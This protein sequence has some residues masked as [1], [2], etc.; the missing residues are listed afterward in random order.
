MLR[1]LIV[2]RLKQQPVLIKIV[3]A[4]EENDQ[5]DMLE[6]QQLRGVHWALCNRLFRNTSYQEIL[7]R[8]H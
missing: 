6:I 5:I 4:A 7:L 8:F 3:S 2:C 1:K